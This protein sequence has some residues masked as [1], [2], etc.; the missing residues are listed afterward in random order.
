MISRQGV[1]LLKSSGF[2]LVFIEMSIQF[3]AACFSYWRDRSRL[4]MRVCGSQ[5]ADGCGYSRM[6][7][8]KPCVRCLVEPTCGRY[9]TSCIGQKLAMEWPVLLKRG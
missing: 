4:I 2:C 5:A 3:D 6:I 8:Q 1:E 9:F 7:S